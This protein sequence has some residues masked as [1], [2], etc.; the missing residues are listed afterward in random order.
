M[1]LPFRLYGDRGFFKGEYLGRVGEREEML[2]LRGAVDSGEHR[3]HLN[4]EPVTYISEEDSAPRLHR[5][6]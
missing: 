3:E 5:H 1:V 6:S 4:N 2:V